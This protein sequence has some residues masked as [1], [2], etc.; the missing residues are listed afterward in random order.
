MKTTFF[1][2]TKFIYDGKDYYTR[3]PLN[4]E[5]LNEY[6]EYFGEITVVCRGQGIENNKQFIKEKQNK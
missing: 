2:D 3:G 1:H 6:K 4:Q 5:K